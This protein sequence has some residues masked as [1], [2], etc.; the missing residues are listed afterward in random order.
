MQNRWSLAGDAFPWA[1]PQLRERTEGCNAHLEEPQLRLRCTKAFSVQL[2]NY[3]IF[4]SAHFR[5]VPLGCMQSPCSDQTLGLLRLPVSTEC[6]CNRELFFFCVRTAPAIR[7]KYIRKMMTKN[8]DLSM[9]GARELFRRDASS[10]MC[11][12]QLTENS[13]EAATSTPLTATL[14]SSSCLQL[15]VQLAVQQCAA[16]QELSPPRLSEKKRTQRD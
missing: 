10:E 4:S 12:E 5:S 16:K 8:R 1:I 3:S 2:W 7:P 6:H 11:G 13:A 14:S 15:A 9:E